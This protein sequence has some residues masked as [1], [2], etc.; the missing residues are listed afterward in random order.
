MLVQHACRWQAGVGRIRRACA[1]TAAK[2]PLGSTR[3]MSAIACSGHFDLG[4]L[5]L[6]GLCWPYGCSGAIYRE[7]VQGARMGAVDRHDW[8]TRAGHR[9]SVLY[10][11]IE[12]T[13]PLLAELPKPVVVPKRVP[14]LKTTPP[15]G[16][17]P[18][19]APAK[20]CSVVSV[21]ASPLVEGGVNF[22]TVPHPGSGMRLR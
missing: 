18:S 10:G 11:T 19:L 22:Q 1:A 16:A 14:S 8:A 13:V 3:S 12:N 9:K 21:Q 4:R 7:A 20:A 2:L 6:R 5:H 15:K 17:A